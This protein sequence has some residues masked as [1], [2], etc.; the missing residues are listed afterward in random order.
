MNPQKVKK[1]KAPHE[2]GEG[3]ETGNVGTFQTGLNMMKVFIGI[4][5]LAT[6]ASFG[7][8]GLVGGVVGMIGIGIIAT[9]TMQL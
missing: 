8:V 4:G 2:S 5:I 6:P 9:Y 3:T 7:K 1:F